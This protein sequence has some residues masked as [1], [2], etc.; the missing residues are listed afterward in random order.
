M[1]RRQFLAT[2]GAVSFRSALPFPVR[3]L[4]RV[5]L[6]LYTVRQLLARDWSGTLTQIAAIGYREVEFAGYFNRSPIEIRHLLDRLGL[7]AP[8]GHFPKED[9]LAPSAAAFDVAAAIG[10]RWVIVA[11]VPPEER[12]SLDGWRRI[13][14]DLNRIG[15]R[16]RRAG[17]RFAYHNQDADFIPSQGQIPYDI[18]LAATDP[19][20]VDLE[21]DLYWVTKGGQDPAA[22][23]AR[24]A[25]RTRLVHVKDSP[26]PPAHR[27][28]DIGRG[29]LDWKRLLAAA[30][31][32]GVRHYFVEHDDPADP[33]SFCRTSYAYLSRLEF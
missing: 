2:V 3:R 5:G 19:H 1:T 11:W 10:H 22:Y 7:A 33:L 4:D 28:V 18:L 23:L 13:A 25:G 26:G 9:L 24:T 15:D 32:A 30:W 16:C 21:I 8:A 29:A 14:D 12:A 6:Q 20:R 17:L 31:R 27:M